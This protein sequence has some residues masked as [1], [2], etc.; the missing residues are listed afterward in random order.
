[1][2]EEQDVSRIISVFGGNRRRSRW[3][4]AGDTSV[5]NVFGRSCLDLREVECRSDEVAMTVL[6]V[7]GSVTILVPE[8]A[9]VRLSGASFLASSDCLVVRSDGASPLPPLMVTAT[10]IMG[11]TKVISLPPGV[12]APARTRRRRVSGKKAAR[13]AAAQR[14]AAAWERA[15]AAEAAL[16]VEEYV[17]TAAAAGPGDG[18]DTTDVAAKIIAAAE[19]ID[20]PTPLD[21][22]VLPAPTM[23]DAPFDPAAFAK[24]AGQ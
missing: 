3:L 15:L 7:L 8:G 20:E 16:A 24:A 22:P 9:D 6:A 2:V 18:A 4:L 1:V 11:R 19:E 23:L 5:L 12:E 13:Q 21:G 14:A 17:A 10:T